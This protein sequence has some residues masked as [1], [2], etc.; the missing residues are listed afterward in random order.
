MPPRSISRRKPKKNTPAL[1]EQSFPAAT[2]AALASTR[3]DELLPEIKNLRAALCLLTGRIHAEP[4][5]PFK[6]LVLT[7][8][9]LAATTDTLVHAVA[10]QVKIDHPENV[11][12]EA[13]GEMTQMNFF[14][15]VV[16]K[17]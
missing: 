14:N 7:M 4:D 2:L 16:K 3:S 15:L 13:W 1:Y 5:M 17:P 10:T 8:R 11:T 12:G 9:C 6:D